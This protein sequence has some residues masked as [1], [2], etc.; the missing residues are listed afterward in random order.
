M[1]AE[2]SYRQAVMADIPLLAAHHRMMFEE[3]RSSGDDNGVKDTCCSP[4]EQ[5]SA[6]PTALA[7]QPAAPAL[8]FDLL[9]AA[10]EQK[11]TEQLADGSCIAWIA[12]CAGKP[13]AS[14]GVTVIKTVPIPEDPT[15]E[16]AFLHSIYTLPS[17]RGQGIASAILEK[18]IAYCRDRGLK[19]V[20]LNA[21]EQGRGVY[22]KKGF[23]PLE[24]V[25][26]L[27]L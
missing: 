25:M 24:R 13:V 18:L 10:Q 2:I 8:D 19:R 12:D 14:G 23:Q 26:L 5:L 4:A 11:L 21:S 27:W 3:M 16:T 9:E 7:T 1:V 22:R 20:Q 15:L 6:F 17:M